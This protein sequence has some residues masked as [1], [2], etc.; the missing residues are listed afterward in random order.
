[1]TDSQLVSLIIAAYTLS[2]DDITSLAESITTHRL[3]VMQASYRRAQLV[4]GLAPNWTPGKKVQRRIEK[5]SQKDAQGIAATYKQ[6]L[7]SFVETALEVE[8]AMK[9]ATVRGWRDVFGSVKEAVRQM[10][11]NV[12]EW[13][14]DFTGWKP[15][16]VANATCG[17]GVSDGTMQFAQDVV[18]AS[19]GD[20]T[21]QD[22]NGG[23]IVDI[24]DMNTEIT[25]IGIAILP[26]ESSNDVCALIAGKTFTMAEYDEIYSLV[27]T[28]PVHAN[29][30]HYASIVRLD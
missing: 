28:L 13:L 3:N 30:R 27:G 20:G 25:N 11:S 15:K 1:M 21:V 7:T 26:A 14:S 29:C 10:V 18:D 23:T 2:Q 16:Q 22:D 24:S 17:G 9:D 19:N 5:Q 4:V 8:K 12:G 6:Y